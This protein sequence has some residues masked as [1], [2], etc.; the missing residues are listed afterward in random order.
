MKAIALT[1]FGIPEALEEL[2]V[3]IPAITNTQVLIEMRVSSINPADILLRSGAILKSPMADKFPAQLPLVL[4]NEVAGIVKEVGEKVRHFK[5]GD[6]VMGMVPMGSYMDY[7]AVEEDHL[8][9]IP[10]SLSF[11]EAGAAPAVALT[12]WQAL[13]EHGRLQPGQRILVQAGAGGV[14]HAAVQLAKQHGAY[15]I[16]TARDYN[17]EFVKGLGA[18]EVFDYTK[19]DFATQITEPV[20]LVLD[21]AMDQSTF[22]STFGTGLPGEIG[23]KNY[24][25][26][27][28]GGTYISLVAFAINQYPKVRDIEAYYFQARPNRPDFESVVRHMKENKLSIYIDETYPFTAQGLLEAYRKSEEMP[29]RGKIVLSKNMV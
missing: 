25:V 12:A 16:A 8:A 11:E 5:P 9:L 14:G 1:S 17:H 27:K 10:E 2:E 19:V 6:R 4:G 15:V 3:P 21:S 23:K 7:V 26:I 18:D 24:S 20:D 13:F 22:G 28:D 29:K